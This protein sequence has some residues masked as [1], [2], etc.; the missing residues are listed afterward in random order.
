MIVKKLQVVKFYI[1]KPVVVETFPYKGK[2]KVFFPIYTIT[3]NQLDIY[4]AGSIHVRIMS[5]H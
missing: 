5:Y 2:Q 3:T 4:I 1:N